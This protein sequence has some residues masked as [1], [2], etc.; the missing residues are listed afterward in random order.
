MTP[1]ESQPVNIDKEIAE[2][3]TRIYQYMTSDRLQSLWR[4]KH[5]REAIFSYAQRPGKALR[6][7]GCLLS[8]AA[9]AGRE[10]EQHDFRLPW[11]RRSIIS[12]R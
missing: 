7:S 10:R 12:G 3:R 4:P 6:G 5:A 11:P 2:R 9:V 8:C 1:L